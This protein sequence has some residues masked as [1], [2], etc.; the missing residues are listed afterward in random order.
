[1]QSPHELKQI[2]ISDIT[3]KIVVDQKVGG[4]EITINHQ[5]DNGIYIIHIVTDKNAYMRKLQIQQ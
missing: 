5:L 4:A 2:I 1:I 3:G